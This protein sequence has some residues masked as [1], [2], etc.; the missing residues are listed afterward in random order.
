[1]ED[2]SHDLDWLIDW[3]CQWGLDYVCELRP[4]TGLLVIPHRAWRSMVVMMS[5]GENFWLVHQSSLSVLLAESYGGKWSNWR[6]KWELYLA[7]ISFTLASGF[8]HAVKSYD[9]GPPALLPTLRKVCCGLLSPLNIHHLGR[10]WTCD[11]WVQ[12][13]AH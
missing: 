12:W 4:P 13:Q 5:A 11:P 6:K 7:S 9:M 10:V 1:M 3:S 2:V 8:L